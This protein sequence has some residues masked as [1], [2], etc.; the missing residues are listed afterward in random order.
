MKVIQ[1]IKIEIEANLSIYNEAK[2]VLDKKNEK[3]YLKMEITDKGPSQLRCAIKAVFT[4][5]LI[6]LNISDNLISGDHIKQISMLIEGNK[7]LRKL[8]LSKN[9]LD[10]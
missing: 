10:H 4:F 5:N 7:S 2:T 8:N 9:Q 3:Q 1:K 6:D